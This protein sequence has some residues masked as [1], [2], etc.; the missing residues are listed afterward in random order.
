MLLQG[1]AA[2]PILTV[3]G[4]ARRPVVPVPVPVVPV[5][6]VLVV[7]QGTSCPPVTAGTSAALSSY[8]VNAAF[9]SFQPRESGIHAVWSRC[10][11]GQRDGSP[12]PM[13]AE[14]SGEAR[15]HQDQRRLS[16][17]VVKER[18]CD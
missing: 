9:M 15:A 6:V 3:N 1:N 13:R 5:L 16:G 14:A 18:V 11:R 7:P 10:W 2:E 12:F 8:G 17:N 4:R